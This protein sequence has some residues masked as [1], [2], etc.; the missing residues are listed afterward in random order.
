LL[1]FWKM[2]VREE[3]GTKDAEGLRSSPGADGL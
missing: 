3:E 1:P 2:E